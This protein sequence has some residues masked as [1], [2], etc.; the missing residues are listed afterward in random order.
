M[1]SY[2]RDYEAVHGLVA[3]T[4]AHERAIVIKRNNF[5]GNATP[6]FCDN[7]LW[8]ILIY[9]FSST[10]MFDGILLLEFQKAGSTQRIL[11]SLVRTPLVTKGYVAPFLMRIL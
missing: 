1:L 6:V 10:S 7:T 5:M 9:V 11:C 8:L 3:R 2:N 4:C